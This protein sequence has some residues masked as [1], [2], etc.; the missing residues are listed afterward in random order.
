MEKINFV[1][2]KQP[3]IN[4]TNLNK[5]QDNIEEEINT[6]IENIKKEI[7]TN[8]EN[9]KTYILDMSHP[10]GSF[11]MSEESTAPNELFG[12]TWEQIKDTFL[13]AC[14]DN[15]EAGSTGGEVTHTL[16]VDEMPSHSHS[17]SEPY[18]TSSGNYTSGTGIPP[19]NSAASG[20]KWTPTVGSTGGGQAHNNMPPYLA[21]YVWKRIA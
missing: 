2:S 15:Y 16:T 8:T 19:H 5:M 17:L 10:I 13:L 20:G 14:G 3:A 18:T 7:D 4:D 1:N 21:V 11:Y 9:L 6:N 12:G